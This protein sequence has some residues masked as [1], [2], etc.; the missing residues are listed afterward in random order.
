M[1]PRPL[2]DRPHRAQVRIPRLC[3]QAGERWRVKVVT[4]PS[5]SKASNINVKEGKG[6]GVHQSA[7]IVP[8]L[9]N[10]NAENGD[11][12]GPACRL[13]VR[14]VHCAWRVACAAW[15]LV[16]IRV[17]VCGSARISRGSAASSF[18]RRGPGTAWKCH[19][20]AFGPRP[21]PLAGRDGVFLSARVL[22]GVSA[23]GGP[24]RAVSGQLV[25]AAEMPLMGGRRAAP[26]GFAAAA[27]GQ[28]VSVPLMVHTHSPTHLST[29]S[30]SNSSL[31]FNSIRCSPCVFFR[32]DVEVQQTLECWP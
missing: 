25:S 4:A 27:D 6:Q 13:Q 20:A 15:S 31:L 9:L 3:Y 14:H 8:A 32:G 5:G 21:R 12:C 29:V 26:A 30:I 24:P 11:F 28:D 18:G 23:D 2:T 16:Q 19:A 17:D 22:T 7:L 1:R 10:K